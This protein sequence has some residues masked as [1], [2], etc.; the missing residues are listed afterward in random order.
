MSDKETF[1]FSGKKILIV[2]D[3]LISAKLISELLKK[4]NVEIQVENN[5]IG[6][7]ELLKT[8]KGFHLVL[9]D[10]QLPDKGGDDSIK[11][12][13]EFSDVPIIA[14]TAYSYNDDKLND[15]MHL[16]NDYI[17]KPIK[18]ETLLSKINQVFTGKNN[19]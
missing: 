2:E 19:R 6:A 12:I 8:N 13:R 15:I 5:A 7:I 16:C 14:Q 4:T 11:E 17:S 9:M 10:L 18:K 3:D 1:D